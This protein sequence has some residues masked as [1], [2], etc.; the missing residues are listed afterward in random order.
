MSIFSTIKKRLDDREDAEHD[1]CLT[2]IVMGL[3][4]LVYVNLVHLQIPQSPHALLAPVLYILFGISVFIWLL[5]S[6]DI[7]KF[8]RGISML[9]DAGIM[10]YGLIH[11]DEVGV[12]ILSSYLFMTFGYGF[13]YGNKYLFASTLLCLACFGIVMEVSTYWNEHVF[14]SYG[15]VATLFILSLYVSTLLSKLHNA[16]IEAK[17]ANEAKSLFLANMSHEIRTPLNGVVGMSSLLAK[18]RLDS[19]QREFAATINASAKTLLTL[20]NEIL[21]I[22]KIEAGKI[23]SEDI[24]FDLYAM[25]NSTVKMLQPQAEVKGLNVN[26]HISPEIPFLLH[27]DAQHIR[28]IFINLLGNA[29]KF[30]QK[31]QIEIYLS[32]ISSNQ[33]EIIIKFEIIDTGIGIP[34]DLKANLFEK[35]TQADDST[36]RKYGG[37]GLGMA[38]AKQLVDT[39]GGVIGYD[40]K[41][42][43]GS[44]FWFVLELEKQRVLTEEKTLLSDMKDLQVLLM[45][46]EKNTRNIIE[47]HLVNFEIPFSYAS[48]VEQALK[49]MQEN[50][51]NNIIILVYKKFLDTDPIQFIYEARNRFKQFCFYLISDDEMGDNEKSRFC[52]AGYTNVIQSNPDRSLLFRSIHS[53]YAGV[54]EVIRKQEAATIYNRNIKT[55]SLKILVGEDNETNQ[56]V[57][58]NILEYENH[59]VTLAE[60]GEVVLDFLENDKFD[61]VIL[62]MHMP[63]MDGLE[64]AKIY[65]FM[66]HAG[67][68]T[69]IIMLS[70]NATREAM[71]SSKDARIDAYLTKPV[72]PDKLIE[73]IYTL[74]R[75]PD[76]NRE[77]RQGAAVYNISDFNDPDNLP[78][79]HTGTLDEIN[80]L[81]KTETFMPNLIQG[82]LRDAENTIVRL[83]EAVTTETFV[84]I[85]ELAHGID[86]SSRS[87]GARKLAKISD[88]LFKAANKQ[89]LEDVIRYFETLKNVFKET[90]AE[91][92][93]YLKHKKDR[94]RKKID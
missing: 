18:T 25:V 16:V 80:K 51:S 58:K 94:L 32:H 21:D 64:A 19:K 50:S 53:A 40:S 88:Q 41:V 31:G 34:E 63:V 62:D 46:P 7:N 9:L 79:L 68:L 57:I 82:Y 56:Q 24:D 76:K 74:T 39:L 71:E 91:L 70:A 15:F 69:P 13:R 89:E 48:G 28:Q 86:G 30:T 78:V 45:T 54:E 4:V 20:I 73:M 14:L 49:H 65:R 29:I 3:V 72:D 44:N 36:T 11:M 2:R 75:Q 8:R 5:I 77:V 60:N 59:R 37:T 67:P 84:E 93:N 23:E 1:Q 12:P 26:I 27:G 61:L 83:Q 47:S 66:N 92:E 90:R 38:I 42:N 6:P 52:K 55:G 43:E 10:S 17:A 35:F 81:A 22:S 33:K 85:S 87:I